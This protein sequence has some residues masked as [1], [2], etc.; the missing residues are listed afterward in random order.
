MARAFHTAVQAKAIAI[1]K[2]D[3]L[4]EEVFIA[5]L[6]HRIGHI[7]FGCFS[8]G[9]ADLL[10]QEIAMTPENIEAAERRVLGFPLKDLS[11]ALNR[12][13][14]LSS[15]MEVAMRGD[16]NDS[17]VNYINLAS[18]MV[19]AVEKGWEN[20]ETS[21][22]L[23]KIGSFLGKKPDEIYQFVTKNAQQARDIAL[24]YGAVAAGRLIPLP[25]RLEDRLIDQNDNN[26]NSVTPDPQLQLHILHELS[27]MLTEKVDLNI[28]ISTVLEGIFRGL[29]MDRAWF[30]ISSADGNLTIRYVLGN[31]VKKLNNSVIAKVDKYTN[32]I[33]SDVIKLGDPRWVDNGRIESNKLSAQTADSMADEFFVMPIKLSKSS[34]GL[35]YCDRHISGSAMDEE[36]YQGFCQFCEH[37]S[38]ALRLMK[39]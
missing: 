39:K 11:L 30:A 12:E 27:S 36:S 26:K 31:D 28:I 38:I 34:T 32:N 37:I 16:K 15:L 14:H 1:E 2:E 17:R 18:S 10:N 24:D 8:Y 9:M 4:P 21:Q 33:F 29:T 6:L 23:D 35:F 5:A 20:E 19:L 22:L 13:W 7:I 25:P 3:G